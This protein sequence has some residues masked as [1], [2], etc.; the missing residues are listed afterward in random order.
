[1]GG[2]AEVLDREGPPRERTESE[3]AVETDP[4]TAGARWEPTDGLASCWVSWESGPR[5]VFQEM[6]WNWCSA[7]SRLCGRREPRPGPAPLAPSG[8][9][10]A[11]SN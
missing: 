3:G 1:M 5:R 4:G 8:A 10:P 11:E 6:A 2:L 7:S 9:S